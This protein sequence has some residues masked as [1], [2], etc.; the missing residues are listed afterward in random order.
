MRIFLTGGTG[1][2]GSRLTE[3]LAGQGHEIVLLVRD[4]RKAEK[5]RNR[6]IGFVTGDIFNTGALKEGMKGCDIVFH[7]AAYAKPW[8]KDPSIPY[9][10]N[11]TGTKNVIEAAAENRVGKIVITSTGGTISYSKDG[12]PV[13]ES[14]YLMTEYNTEYERTKA[15]AERMAFE[16]SRNGINITVVNPTRVYGPGLISKSN[17]LTMIIKNYISGKWRIMPGNGKSIGNYVFIDD[18]VEGHILAATR[19]RSGE[20]YILGGENLTFREFF[21]ISGEVAGRE[22]ILVPLPEGLMKFIIVLI[23]A[24]SK[25]FKVPPVITRDWLDKFMKNWI[26]SSDKAVN[27]LGYCITPFREGVAKTISWLKTA[28][29]NGR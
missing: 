1:F 25:I 3:K 5:F 6:N 16:Y 24:F 7:M 20:R 29:N 17:S 4:P 15:E 11:V 19:G 21:K 28:E 2:I 27:E 26:V 18:V 12:K 14:T 22:R 9:R 13:D 8:S 10:T 23:S